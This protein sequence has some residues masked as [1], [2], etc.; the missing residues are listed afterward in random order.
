MTQ[1][2]ADRGYLQSVCASLDGRSLTPVGGRVDRGVLRI[3]SGLTD[4]ELA[5][6][7]ARFELRFPPDLRALLEHG[8][9]TGWD[10][11]NWRDPDADDYVRWALGKPR[12]AMEFDIR[13]NGFWLPEWGPAPEAEAERMAAAVAALAEAPR[14]VPVHA[15]RYLPSEPHAAGNPVVRVRQIIDT[16][17]AAD[18]L[19][20]YLAAEFA[21]PR[22]AWAATASG[23]RTVSF[24]SGLVDRSET[25]ADLTGA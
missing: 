16:V 21:G 24:W 4:A 15:D 1:P 11:P 2:W 9:P 23:R 13:H 18:D 10:L 7:E 14:L 20:G 8:L 5:A 12:R 17:H 22:P 19:A 6:A 25:P 3:E